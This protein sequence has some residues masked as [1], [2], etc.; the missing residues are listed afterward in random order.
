MPERCH[1]CSRVQ[2]LVVPSFGTVTVCAVCAEGTCYVCTR[3]CDGCDE[4]V[5][6]RCAEEKE[7][8]SFCKRC[9]GAWKESRGR[10]GEGGGENDVRG[11]HD[12]KNYTE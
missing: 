8:H 12:M 9:M 1:V 11:I 2:S 5:C 4:T 10:G 6:S 7:V 3:K